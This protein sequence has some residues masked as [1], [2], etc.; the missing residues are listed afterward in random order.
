[1]HFVYASGESIRKGDRIRYAGGSGVVEFAAD[2]EL[3]DPETAY[4]VDEF[5]G[6]CMLLTEKFG[7]VFVEKAEEDE[8]LEFVARQ[9]R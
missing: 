6:G 7:R 1:M 3:A 8:A 9:S 5:G 2:P 4:Y